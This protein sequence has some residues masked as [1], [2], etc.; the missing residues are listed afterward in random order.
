MSEDERRELAAVD[1][2]LII[3][4]SALSQS[5]GSVD[6]GVAKL[7]FYPSFYAYLSS[8]TLAPGSFVQLCISAP[9][10]IFK[11]IKVG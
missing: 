8:N 6:G 11:T 9:V 3:S 10:K 5:L 1:D 4:L 2:Y 7:Q